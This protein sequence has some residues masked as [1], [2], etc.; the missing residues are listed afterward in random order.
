MSTASTTSVAADL[1]DYFQRIGLPVPEGADLPD[2]DMSTLSRVVLGHAQS[3][4]FENL[5][6]F[7]GREVALDPDSIAAKLVRGGRG[8]YCFE[9]NS[10]LRSMLDALGYST[11]GLA[12]RV[13]WNCPAGAP[14]PARNHMLLRVDLPEGSFIVDVGFGLLTLTGVLEMAPDVEQTTPHGSFRFV[15]D[16][17]AY[18]EEARIGGEWRALYRFDLSEQYFS[19]YSVANWHIAT[20]P[21]SIFVNRLVIARP[22]TDCRYALSGA[23]SGGATFTVHHLDGP[24][25]RH[26]LESPAAVCDVLENR[27]LVDLSGLQPDLSIALT[28]LF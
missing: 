23:K 1:A 21:D 11:T 4:P 10:L 17:P 25:E 7:I 6:T 5:D 22:D 28:C 18:V 26:D 19:D 20:H 3:I 9:H 2:A 13:V 27:F 15:P 12:G 14:L 16:G 24:S 8:G